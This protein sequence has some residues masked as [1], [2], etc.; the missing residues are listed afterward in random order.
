MYV[1]NV[2]MSSVYSEGIDFFFVKGYS[3]CWIPNFMHTL[4]YM[5]LQGTWSPP[6]FSGQ[7]DSNI[8]KLRNV[9]VSENHS[10]YMLRTLRYVWWLHV[11]INIVWSSSM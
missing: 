6:G 1:A 2:I 11:T 4:T 3:K 9:F 5:Q 10:D 7:F 8:T